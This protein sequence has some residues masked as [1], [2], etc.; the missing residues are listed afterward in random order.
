MEGRLSTNSRSERG[1]S[2]RQ[3]VRQAGLWLASVFRRERPVSEQVAV[4]DTEYD[5]P[6]EWFPYTR[7]SYVLDPDPHN[8]ARYPADDTLR[9]VRSKAEFNAWIEQQRADTPPKTF[10]DR[11][12]E[13]AA[14]ES[15]TDHEQMI[16]PETG[17]IA[18]WW[19]TPEGLV[20]ER[21]ILPRPRRPR[22][23]GEPDFFF[24]PNDGGIKQ[25]VPDASAQF[26]V[27]GPGQEW[28]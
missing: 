10:Q 11:L 21:P 25:R 16:D 27:Q 20:V 3:R 22:D 6:R 14:S 8:Y 19:N 5:D 24:D 9:S 13:I 1:L 15:F 2:R 7:A 28:S 4:S 12:G 23:P 17:E 26:I 18:D